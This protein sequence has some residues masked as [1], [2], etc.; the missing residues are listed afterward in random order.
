MDDKPNDPPDIEFYIEYMTDVAVFKLGDEPASIEV[1]DLHGLVVTCAD[2]PASD[3]IERESTNEHVVPSESSDAFPAGG[4]PDFDLA[5]V[6][7]GDNK[8]ILE[9][10]LTVG[11]EN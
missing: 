7:A 11:G 1:P 10:E 5:I 4:G 6:R 2:E 8:V 9:G 3:W